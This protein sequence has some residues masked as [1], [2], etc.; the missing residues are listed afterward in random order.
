MNK[1]IHIYSWDEEPV[2]E[3]PS[4]FGDSTGYATLSGHTI[5]TAPTLRRR[6]Q[7]RGLYALVLPCLAVLALGVYALTRLVPLLHA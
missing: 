3:R 2:D 4:E 6:K 1:R 5:V 7:G